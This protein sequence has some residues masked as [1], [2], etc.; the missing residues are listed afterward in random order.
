VTWSPEKIA[1]LVD[2]LTIEQKIAQL[3]GL[4]VTD[5]VVRTPGERP[6]AGVI[7]ADR[8]PEVR[9]HGAGHLSLAW[10][11]GP[12]A[13]ALRS[14]LASLQAAARDITPFGIG[15]LVHFEAV[16]GMMH[17][18]GSQF[19][20]AWAQAAPERPRSASITTTWWA[21]QPNATARSRSSYWRASDLVWWMTWEGVD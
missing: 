7:D 16:N 21:G 2:R 20:T 18:C 3:T 4:S 1:N 15:A 19:P 9:P 17:A 5:L 6:R 13:D 12:D 11:L 10:F 14:G 8:L